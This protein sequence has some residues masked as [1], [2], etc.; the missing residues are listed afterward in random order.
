[1]TFLVPIALAGLLVLPLVLIIHL[2]R[3]SQQRMRIPAAFLWLDLQRDISS[4]SRWKPPRLS[5]LL[6]LQLLI[7]A[8]VALALARPADEVS[9]NRHIAIVLDASG[10]MQAVDV[11]PSRFEA[12]RAR[13]FERLSTLTSG[14]SATL[15]RAGISAT[16]LAT[17]DPSQ[18][19]RALGEI[20]PGSGP[21]RIEDAIA[22]ASHQV[23][24]TPDKRGEIVVLTDAAVADL[25]PG[26]TLSAPVEFALVGGSGAN[27]AIVGLQVRAQPVG[28]SQT[29]FVELANFE[30]R[31]VR[32]PMRTL[33]DDLVLETREVDIP[34]Q[35]FSRVTLSLPAETGRVTVQLAGRDALAIDDF[36]EVTMP[37][38][39]PRDV[40][41]VSRFPAPLRQALESIPFVRLTVITPDQVDGTETDLT[42]LDGVLPDPL[43]SGPLL[44]VNPPA[45]STE[46]LVN[47]EMRAASVSSVD[48]RHP[49]ML[50]VDAAAVRVGKAA[51]I[52]AP[53]W[54]RSVMSAAT[55]PLVLDGQ[56]DGRPVV[57][58]AFDT[59]LSGLEKSIAFPLLTSN[60]VTYLLSGG[61]GPTIA[62]GQVMVLPAPGG[63][64]AADTILVRPDGQPFEL[65]ATGNELRITDTEQVGRYSVVDGR[66]GR[67]LRTF[68]VNLDDPL[69]SDIRPRSLEALPATVISTVSSA[70]HTGT[71]WWWPLVAVALVALTLEWL[72]FARRG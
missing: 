23:A 41:L 63:E 13:A 15:V 47:G 18:A 29:A 39:R 9:A 48:A 55:G 28:R 24:Q 3:G 8:A 54:M 21:P 44:I 57:V 5:L 31:A 66:D 69:E 19:R 17:G 36:A 70:P 30:D 68:S 20:Q 56:R 52:V 67:V 61:L 37:S 32:V 35:G 59:L 6:L 25:H 27:Q 26:G 16:L 60:A 46:L 64:G 11:E 22:I 33:G 49:L 53:G 10:S 14:D 4:R 42:V 12:A 38:T 1:M 50:G 71:E 34:A 72:V 51:R 2:L 7:A 62:P 40:R 43:P 65:V 45:G 58:F